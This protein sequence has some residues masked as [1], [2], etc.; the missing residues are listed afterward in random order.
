V[1]LTAAA[2]LLAGAGHQAGILILDRLVESI[3]TF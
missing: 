1:V 3:L 2:F